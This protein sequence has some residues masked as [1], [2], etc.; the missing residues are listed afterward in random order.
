MDLM[1]YI[2][3]FMFGILIGSFLNVCIYRIPRNETIVSGRSHCMDCNK[4]LKWY[5]MVP[6]LS[7]VLLRG[8]CRFCKRQL[9]LQ[10]PIVEGLN[11][12]LYVTVFYI[13]GWNYTPVVLFN[14][15]YCIAISTLII[16]SLIDHRTYTIPAG[17]N[18]TLLILGI[19]LI[20][21]K[22]LAFDNSSSLVIEHILGFFLVSSLL[23]IIFYATKG[24]GIGGG[25]VKLMASAGL[26]LGWKSILLAF[27][28]GSI[29][30]AFIHL[31]K[32]KV[33][34]ADRTL[35]FGPYLS[36]GITVS[37]LYGDKIINW[38]IS[39]ILQL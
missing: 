28:L 21:I 31:I 10:Y 19:I 36:A 4:D 33:K 37:M 25:D 39:S 12:L 23:A 20:G 14:I 5:D 38:Y 15:I 32:M 29:L 9:P 30:A 8:R 16:I 27:M 35:A 26:L 1:I 3:I 18:L 22:Y 2:T 6:I 7:Y 13:Y 11:G 17:L 34:N 24:K